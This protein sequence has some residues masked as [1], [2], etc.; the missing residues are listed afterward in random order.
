MSANAPSVSV[1]VLSTQITRNFPSLSRCA[2]PLTSMPRRAARVSPHTATTGVDN[3]SA[4]GHATT[5]ST[6]AMYT[7]FVLVSPAAN[8]TVAS[9]IAARTTIGV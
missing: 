9:K 3:T 6:H 7:Y 1:P 4:H 5:R 2:L 8:G